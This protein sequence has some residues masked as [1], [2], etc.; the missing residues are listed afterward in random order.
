MLTET[1]TFLET[2]VSRTLAA[3]ENGS[4]ACRHCHRHRTSEIGFAVAA[5]GL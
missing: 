1:A 2:V 4:A 5:A 3:M